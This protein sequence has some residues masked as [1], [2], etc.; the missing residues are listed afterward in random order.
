MGWPPKVPVAPG[1]K[2]R[3]SNWNPG[4]PRESP[5]RLCKVAGEAL[6][7]LRRPWEPW[8]AL[9]EPWE[10]LGNSDPKPYLWGLPC[11]RPR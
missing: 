7:A 2:A 5:R 10:P 3:P 9:K 11:G 4:R 8:E 6:G 1:R